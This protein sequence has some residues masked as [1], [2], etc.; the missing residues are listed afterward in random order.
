VGCGAIGTSLVKAIQRDFRATAHVRA[1]YDIDPAK[2]RQLLV[3]VRLPP[4]YAVRSLDAL[5]RTSDLVIECAQAS[6]AHT[7]ACRCLKARRD[8]MIMS[9]AGVL[10]HVSALRRRAITSQRRVY[11]PSGAIAGMDAVR[12]AREAGI[13]R[14]TLETRKPPGA[15]IGVA[16]ARKN[17]FSPASCRRDTVL[18]QGPAHRAVKFFPQNINVAAVLSL[19]G[20][21]ARKTVVKIIAS[22]TE[23]R[24]VHEVRIESRAGN[25][26]TRVENVVH[27]DNPKTSFLAVSSALALL[28]RIVD[29]VTVGA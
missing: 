14:A 19:A 29:P 20:S 22:P 25:I 21:G 12:A 8:V 1:V 6:S 27:P 7:I 23:K 3:S 26:V 4:R 2:A 24:N 18:F 10:E 17:N 13:T 28:R 9:A 11:I 15:F 16:Y 5:I